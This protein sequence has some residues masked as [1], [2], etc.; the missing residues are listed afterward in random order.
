L[1]LKEGEN[2]KA[3][4][5]KSLKIIAIKTS[6]KVYISDNISGSS[7]HTTYLERYI[8]DGV[9]PRKTYRNDWFEVDQIPT[10]TERVVP[11]Q[12]INIRYELNSKYP[13]SELTPRVINESYIGEDSPYEEVI[14]L[15]ERKWDLTDETLE[16]IEFELTVIEELDEFE[17]TK[18]EFQLQYNLL[19][20]INTHPVLLSTKP[21]SM[22]RE[23]SY[24]I[25]REYIKNNINPHYA[26]VT[27]DYDFC[28]SVEKVIELYQPESYEVNINSGTKRKPKYETKYKRNR[29]AKIYEI[30]PKSYQSYPVVEPFSGK[31]KEDLKNNIKTFLEELISKINE[32][33]VECEHCKGRGVVWNEKV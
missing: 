11:P 28:F 18:Q 20:R 16:E 19:D 23:E 8:F 13:E 4:N 29:T 9:K 12:Q 7:Y 17:I 33:V 22:S 32:P 15:Y 26:R 24:K 21:C 3:K 31:N 5:D 6:T 2:M 14:G 27:S 30:A 10:K 1:L 25:I